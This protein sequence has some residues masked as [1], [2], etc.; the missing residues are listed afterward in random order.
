ME[1]EL[2]TQVIHQKSLPKAGTFGGGLYGALPRTPKTKEE[3]L[4]ILIKKVFFEYFA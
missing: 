3:S 4:L 2:I 1:A